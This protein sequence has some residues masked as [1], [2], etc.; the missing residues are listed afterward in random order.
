[1]IDWLTG[2]LGVSFFPYEACVDI[3]GCMAWCLGGCIIWEW[4]SGL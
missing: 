2:W 3:V 1:M 4:V